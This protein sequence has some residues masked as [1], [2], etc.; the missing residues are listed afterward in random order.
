MAS[1]QRREPRQSESSIRR[2]EEWQ[3]LIMGAAMLLLGISG[4]AYVAGSIWA[5]VFDAKPK[6]S[7]PDAPP[8]LVYASDDP[9]EFYGSAAFLGVLCLAMLYFGVAIMRQAISESRARQASQR[10]GG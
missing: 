7:P 8:V 3:I 10:R 6:G 5:G 1:T 9:V 4:L 2:W